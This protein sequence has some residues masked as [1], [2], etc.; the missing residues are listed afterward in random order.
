MKKLVAVD[1]NSIMNRAFYGVMSS[2]MLMN[3]E[4]VYTNAIFGFLSILLKL[5]N[6]EN[7]D[8]VCVAFD[9]KAPTFRHKKYD[10]YKATRKG[11]PDELRMQM[12]IIKEILE[13]MNIKI[14]EMEGYEADDILGTMASFGEKNDINVLLLT[15]DR[16]ALQLTSD[17]VTVRIPTT[18]MGKTESTDY[19]PSVVREKF[20]I[21]P[22]QFI[23]IKG[24][25]GDTSDNIPGVPGVGEKT[26]F[27]LITKYH[28]IDKIY[29]SLEA[30]EELEGIKG[31]L[32]EKILGNKELAYLSKDLGTIFREVPLEFELEEIAKKEFDN[33]KLYELFKK[34][35][36][37]T[38]IDRLELKESE[39]GSSEAVEEI[40]I[41]IKDFSELKLDDESNQIAYY[42]DKDSGAIAVYTNT[43]N[44]V[45]YYTSHPTTENLK[46]IFESEVA[47]IG[48]EEKEDYLKLK[49]HGIQ[50]KN[51][52]F[53]VTIAAYLLNPSKSTYKL[54][55]LILEE[56]KIIVDNGEEKGK[57]E[58][59]T[60]EGFSAGNEE[61][62]SQEDEKK[63]ERISKY[64][65]Y[66]FDCKEKY[67]KELKDKE[68][69]HLFTDIE[70]PLM[71]VLA[72]MEYVGV[73]VDKQMLRDYS[74]SLNT[75]VNDLT[76]E[77][78]NLAGTE[79]NINSPKQLGEVL[80]EKLQLPVIKKTKSGYSTDSDVL[81]KLLEDH[82][83]VEKV[84]EYRTLNKLKATYVDGMLPLINAETGRIH[85]KFNQTVTATGRISCTDPNLQNIPIRT[86][87][88]REL[89]KIF[90]A[91]EGYTLLDADYSQVELRV[92]AHISGDETMIHAFQNDVDIHAVTAS[93]VFNVPLEEVTKQMRSEAKAVN[94]GI[95]YGISDFGLATNIHI[96]RRRAKEYIEKYFEKYPKI[97]EYMD[98]SV[99]NCKEKGYVETLWGRRRYVPEI[100]SNNFNV[101]QFGERVAMNAPIQGTAADIIKIAMVN[102]E[103]ELEDRK[104]E[105]KLII[106]VHDEL[107]IET[108]ESEIEVVKELLVRNMENVIQM[109]VPLKVDANMGRTWF[110]AH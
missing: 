51:M 103:K 1:G 62:Q 97:K 53:D 110:E 2:K 48:F 11:M 28:D 96:S 104:L 82:P 16:D 102:I 27:S 23:Q 50:A 98:N 101:R 41:E 61:A 29:H 8:Y 87:L 77:I 88:G 49:R 34:L 90:I 6:E 30:G 47:K 74:I 109:A 19:T 68:E 37:K 83:I 57:V 65:K 33:D 100:K 52:M 73:F 46:Y 5:L 108:K 4:G 94:F 70:M 12:P 63:K 40:S 43:E 59:I 55:D 67:E 71:K 21:E 66:I 89:R 105:S 81:E 56:L 76:K 95:V 9:L 45:V 3:S 91:K 35:E 26:A 93:Q 79:F 44:S 75:S 38:F 80:F 17:R 22:I 15:G 84:L 25:M 42:W 39:N 10:G 54:N 13:D 31:K 20:G 85:A 99:K 60:L 69:Y 24:L 58:Q 18:R 86:E 7:P 92:L 106:Q 78:W 107:L 64:A 14:F 36:L 32:K 72:E